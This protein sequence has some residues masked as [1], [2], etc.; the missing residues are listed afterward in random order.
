MVMK[1]KLGNR[2]TNHPTNLEDVVG[3]E[4]RTKFLGVVPRNHTD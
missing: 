3:D 4:Y 2:N 1:T